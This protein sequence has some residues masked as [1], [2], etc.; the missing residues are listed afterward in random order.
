MRSFR[1]TS[2]V[3][4]SMAMSAGPG[5]PAV[6]IRPSAASASPAP[7][8]PF[9][10]SLASDASIPERARSSCLGSTSTSVTS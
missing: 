8:F 10:T 3:A 2:S 4:A 5:S 9:S 6:A 1:S 7:T